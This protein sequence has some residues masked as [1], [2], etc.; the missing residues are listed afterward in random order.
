MVVV[1]VV[2]AVVVVAVLV[3]VVLCPHHPQPS[4]KSKGRQTYLRDTKSFEH[5]SR[6]LQQASITAGSG[7]CTSKE[8]RSD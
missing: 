8:P 4:T 3:V 1:V 7:S 2:A 5:R 6:L